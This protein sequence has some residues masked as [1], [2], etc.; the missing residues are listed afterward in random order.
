MTYL[1]DDQKKLTSLVV[2]VVGRLQDCL[3]SVLIL[4][5][6]LRAT[7]GVWVSSSATRAAASLWVSAFAAAASRFFLF[8]SAISSGDLRGHDAGRSTT[9]GLNVV[10]FGR[11]GGFMTRVRSG[12]EWMLSDGKNGC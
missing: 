2:S 6:L 8:S 10:R 4:R 1:I 12:M 9:P 11:S 7:T 3:V 5:P